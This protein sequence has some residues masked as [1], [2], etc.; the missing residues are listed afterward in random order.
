MSEAQKN[1][2]S[3]ALPPHNLEA[4]ESI[5]GGILL[6]PG[7]I[8]RVADKIAPEA[9]YL[10]AHQEIYRAAVTLSL[11]GKPT[12]LMTVTSWLEDRGLLAGVGGVSKLAQ[13]AE[14]TVSAINID[15]YGTLVGDK[16]LR[17]ELIAA[18]NEIVGLGYDTTQ[19]LAT[20]LDRA[21]QKIFNLTQS[22]Q[23]EGLIP[24]AETLVDAFDTIETLQQEDSLPGTKTDFYDF[25]AMTGGLQKSDLVILAG[26]PAMG[27]TALG[28]NIARNVAAD[29][30]LPVAIFSLEM[31]KE[32]LAQR[33][34]AGEAQIPSNQLRAGKIETSDFDKLS[35]AIG[36]LS[37]LPIYID[38]TANTTIMQMRSQGRNSALS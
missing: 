13:L 11:Q 10:K 37:E 28:L 26:R 32:Q 16:A 24:L 7:A 22:R 6:D 5:L 3:D 25:D 18:G 27:K 1:L 21:E 4:E 30:K 38:D 33:L 9:F 14:Q 15:G 36:R 35:S 29:L 17:R 34:L 31:S 19:E 23:Q 20:A 2:A 12:D 8:A